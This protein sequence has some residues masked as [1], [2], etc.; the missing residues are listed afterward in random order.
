[1][2]TVYNKRN[3]IATGDLLIWT[4]DN[5]RGKSDFYLKLV[6]MMT[7]S[8]FGHVSIAW[9]SGDSLQHVEA[10]QPRIAIN[11]IPMGE[12]FYHI[13][14]NRGIDDTHMDRF[15]QDKIG[16]EYSFIDAICGYF[17]ITLKDDN[18]WQCVELCNMFY[19][20]IG[21]NVGEI[22]V[23]NKFV[24]AIMDHTGQPMNRISYVNL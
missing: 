22:Y 5:I 10:T 15:F 24:R 2:T 12:T 9:K 1:M 7:I 8:D 17:G 16:L 6:R 14:I 4:G 21:L 11:P 20:S 18:R 13:P 23:P 19:R 3:E